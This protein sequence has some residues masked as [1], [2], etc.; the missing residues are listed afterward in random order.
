MVLDRKLTVRPANP[1]DRNAIM[2]LTRFDERVHVHLDWKPVEEWLGTQPFLLAERGRRVMGGLACPPDPADTA[3]LRLF[4]RVEGVPA[5]EMWTLLWGR[6]ELMLRER[7]VRQMAALSMDPWVE[8]LLAASGFEQTHAV[9]VLRRARAPL[10]P[11]RVDAGLSVRPATWADRAAIIATDTAAFS[12]PWQMSPELIELA[13]DRADY[14][15][16][17]E[18]AGQIAGYQLCTPSHPG[19]HLARLAV[20]PQHQGRGIGG[21]LLAELLD[22]YGQRGAREITVNT[23]DT[24]A[25]SLKLYQRY[26]FV[27]TGARFPVYQYDLTRGPQ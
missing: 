27:T 10:P 13:I 21:A 9:V 18:L 11:V 8:E 7:G 26:G 19:A 12:S 22:H 14:L 5:A 2:T 20:L 25:A 6:A 16:V 3:W 4:T 15:S 24:N 1:A 23:Q 17:A